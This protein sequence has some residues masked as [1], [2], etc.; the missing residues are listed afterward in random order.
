MPIIEVRNLHKRYGDRVAVH[1]VSFTV[2]PGEIFG[3]IGPN[4]AGKTTTVE[5]I[6]GL[7]A[8]DSG[9][10]KV[11]GLDPRRNRAELRRRVGVQLQ[12]SELP[13]RIKVGEAL[14]LYASFYP[15]PADPAR[16]LDELGL[17]DQRTKAYGK[18]SGGQKQ[19]VSIALALVG[20][21]E[22]A[23]LDEL[24]TGLDPQARRETWQLIED[25][26]TRGVT[27]ILVT[28]FMAEAQRLCDRIAMIDGGRVAAL[29]SPAALVARAGA[30][31]RLTFRTASPLDPQVLSTLPEVRSVA[32]SGGHVTVSGTGDLLLA[33]AAVL[34]RHGVP[35]T[36]LQLEQP[37]LDDA[38]ISLTTNDLT[39]NDAAGSQS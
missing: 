21:P 14:D 36:E 13:E 33:V 25:I 23:I 27:V 7:R 15:N 8:A 6:G 2:E 1:D 4:G 10:V 39:T 18:L 34:A 22:I 24:T 17:A 20:N 26:R 9:T 11:L 5:T 32:Q 31:H 30:E 38:F 12:T 35:V 37:T 16:L 29:E 19:R 28:H 3:I